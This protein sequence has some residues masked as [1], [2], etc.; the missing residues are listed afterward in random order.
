M[1]TGK[2]KNFEECAKCV[3]KSGASIVTVAVRRV[4]IENK[5]QYLWITLTQ[6]NYLFAKYCR[7]F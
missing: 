7:L 4:N 5:N 3:K 6:K 2:Y 1:G